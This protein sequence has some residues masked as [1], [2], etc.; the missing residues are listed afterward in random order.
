MSEQRRTALSRRGFLRIGATAGLALGVGISATSCSSGGTG[1]APEFRFSWWG[2]SDRNR[3]T[4]DVIDLYA[5]RHEGVSITPSYGGYDNYHEKLLTSAAGG[6]AP[7][8]MQIQQSLLPDFAGRGVLADLNTF[9]DTL[10]LDQ[11]DD[12]TLESG[13]FGGVLTALSLGDSA[14]GMFMDL[15]VLDDAGV[16]LPEAQWTW[17]EFAA[18]A[19]DLT[20]RVGGGFAGTDNL[21]GNMWALEIF[22]RQLQGGVG[23]FDETGLALE[24]DTLTEWFTFWTELMDAGAVVSPEVTAEQSSDDSSPLILNK[25][26]NLVNYALLLTSL[27]GMT[28]HELAIVSLPNVDPAKPAGQQWVSGSS[29][30]TI[31]AE[32]EQQDA[33]ADFAGFFL[34][35]VD[36]GLALRLDRG[37]PP[38]V[39]VREALAPTLDERETAVLE[40]VEYVRASSENKGY[41]LASGSAAVSTALAS[42]SENLAFGSKAVAEAVGGFFDD[43]QR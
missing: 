41:K 35:D 18:F 15:T 42:A 9:R 25:A 21:A 2:S 12:S 26:V 13:T 7:D 28:D 16:A 4:Q 3:V 27:S 22:A 14:P 37:I 20:R 34:N 40:Y 6:N 30:L 31:Y 36:A 19:V 23:V 1:G 29:W 24:E 10:E 43:S 38:N 17:D 33:A 39:E 8:L 32:S 5:Q 11:Y